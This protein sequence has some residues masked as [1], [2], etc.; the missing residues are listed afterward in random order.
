MSQAMPVV[1]LVSGSGSNLQAIIDAMQAGDLPIDIRAVISN[2]AD[3][4]G[5]QRAANAGI[6]T[7][8]I[9]HRD[10][11]SREDFDHALQAA[12]DAHNPALLILAGFMRILSHDFVE[13]YLGRMINI[14]PALLPL[15]PG[16]NTHERALQDAVKE[17]GA[18]VHFVTTEVD[19]GPLILQAH[20]PVQGNDTPETLAARVL[21]QEHRIFPQAIRWFAEGRLQMQCDKVLLDD[22]PIPTTGLDFSE[23][24]NN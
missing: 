10:Y 8:V 22:K 18:T 14:H 17:H 3:A 4:Y 6:H 11:P 9:N 23:I 13:H 2:R 1:I 21:E 15:F 24:T 12:I 5:L 7:E 20:V 16:L 19:G